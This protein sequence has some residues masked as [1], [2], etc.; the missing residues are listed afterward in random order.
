MNYE[1]PNR[2]AGRPEGTTKDNSIW[3]EVRGGDLSASYGRAS[4]DQWTKQLKEEA[5]ERHPAMRQRKM[6]PDNGYFG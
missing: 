1:E 4:E 2:E 3:D 5:K 6:R